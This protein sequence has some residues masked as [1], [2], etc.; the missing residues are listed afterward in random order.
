MKTIE[1]YQVVET[2]HHVTER[3]CDKCGLQAI[4]NTEYGEFVYRFDLQFFWG[5]YQEEKV[6][7]DGW[8]IEDLCADCADSLKEVLEK[9]GFKTTPRQL[10]W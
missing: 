3:K 9:H 2:Y 5:R 10:D 6:E 7:M 1:T 4:D 8:G